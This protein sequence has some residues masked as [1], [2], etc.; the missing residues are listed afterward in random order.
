MLEICF[1]LVRSWGHFQTVSFLNFPASLNSH[2]C[3]GQGVKKEYNLDINFYKT[4]LESE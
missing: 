4:I 2:E 1:S 3:Q